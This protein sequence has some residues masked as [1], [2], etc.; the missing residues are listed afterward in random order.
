MC[1]VW[2]YS[3][4]FNNRQPYTAVSMMYDDK[5]DMDTRDT[6]TQSFHNTKEFYITN[7]NNNNDSSK[8]QVK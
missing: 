5:D 7:N 3:K 4:N 6:K 1:Y 2:I 8:K